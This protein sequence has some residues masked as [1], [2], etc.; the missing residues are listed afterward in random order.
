MNQAGI[1]AAVHYPIPLHLQGA[2]TYLGHQRGSFPKT[3]SAA[4][5]MI[6]L[7]IFPGITVDE[8]ERIVSELA[9]ALT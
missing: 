6:S 9:T 3:E 1:G 7:P 5:R 8:Q 4:G 2:L